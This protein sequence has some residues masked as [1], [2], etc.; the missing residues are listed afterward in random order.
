MFCFV[1]HISW[2]FLHG[3]ELENSWL[4]GAE[5]PGKP[6]LKLSV[7]GSSGICCLNSKNTFVVLCFGSHL[8]TAQCLSKKWELMLFL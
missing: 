5:H 8:S 6:E 2:E 3:K 4:L 1:L 7:L